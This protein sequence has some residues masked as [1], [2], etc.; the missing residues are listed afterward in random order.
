M[1]EVMK[2]NSME[3]GL[4]HRDEKSALKEKWGN[5]HDT[6]GFMKMFCVTTKV[7]M[8]MMSTNSFKQSTKHVFFF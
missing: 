2:D 5:I 1:C 7:M 8:C 3:D 6:N 4:Q